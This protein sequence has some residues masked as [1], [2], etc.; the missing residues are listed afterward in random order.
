MG[1][2]RSQTAGALRYRSARS[3]SDGVAMTQA[4][5]R[6][7][8]ALAQARGAEPLIV[9]PQH[10][11]EVPRETAV[12]RMVLDAGHIPYLLVWLPSDWRVP[13][14]RHP[15]ARGA[16]AMAAAVAKELKLSRV[17]GSGNP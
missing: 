17:P 14:D 9:V 10:R 4:A 5:L 16:H 15:D 2:A 7:T 11:P 6:E 3:I 8:I 12:R 13:G 1:K